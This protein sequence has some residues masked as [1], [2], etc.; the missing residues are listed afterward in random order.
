MVLFNRL[1]LL[2]F[3]FAMLCV[4]GSAWA[5]DRASAQALF[6]AGKKLVAAG[7]YE[8]ACPKFE[9]SQR[10]DPATGTLFNLADCYE[11]QGRLATAWATFLQAGM[12]AKAAGQQNRVQVAHDRAESLASRVPKLVLLV[13]GADRTPALEVKR[14]GELIGKAQW[15]EPIPVD[16]GTHLISAAAPG[17]KPWSQ[18]VSLAIGAKVSVAIPELVSDDAPAAEPAAEP[19]APSKQPRPAP[20]QPVTPAS[21]SAL[22]T[23]RTLAIVSGSIGLVGVGVGSWFGLQAISKHKQAS[24]ACPSLCRDAHDQG[25]WDD[26]TRAGNISTIAFIAG[27]LGLAGGAL[28][29]FTASDDSR[30]EQHVALGIAPGNVRVR[31]SW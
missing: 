24:D 18:S 29:W 4:S 12:R 28:L 10:L 16:P 11:R 25:L 15:G 27:G 31:V 20:V 26:A 17:R 21:R 9:E 23:R 5:N 19:V 6:D 8:H 30:K 1:G 2:G 7:D 3:G 22:G 14:D 13:G